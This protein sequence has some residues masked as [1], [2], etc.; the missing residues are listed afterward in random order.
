MNTTIRS[1]QLKHVG[2]SRSLQLVALINNF[3]CMLLL[4]SGAS[5][6]FIGLSTCVKFKLQLHKRKSALD[7]RLANRKILKSQHFVEQL[8]DFNHF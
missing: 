7:V 8:V 6:N 5:N 4:D 3:K 2:T 1:G